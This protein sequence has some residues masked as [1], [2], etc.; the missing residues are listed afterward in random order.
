MLFKI[1]VLVI[2]SG[3]LGVFIFIYWRLFHKR[4]PIVPRSQ[5]TITPKHQMKKAVLEIK[6]IHKEFDSPV[7]KGIS[8]SIYQ[9]ET[10]AL[11]GRSGSGK[12]A[13][14]KLIAGLLKPDQGKILFKG[15]DIGSMDENTLLELRKSISYVFQQGA[16]FDFLDVRENIAYPLREMGIKDEQS[17]Q[18]RVNYLL[19]AVEMKD[20]SNLRNDELSAGSKKQVAIARAIAN[21]PEVI[22]YDEPTTGVD[23]M[24]KKSLSHL[25]RKLNKENN[26][27]SIVVTHDLRCIETVADRMILIKNGTVRFEGKLNEFHISSDPYV[28]AFIAGR[29]HDEEPD[30]LQS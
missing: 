5:K 20:S 30:L 6:D 26:L 19:D 10:L 17:I 1:L 24:I 21:N 16:I 25:I 18:D 13:T 8:F 3:Y 9:G 15:K 23:P 11:L 22:L 2:F 28:Q 14:L 27:T 29:L 12:S 4:Q 7:L